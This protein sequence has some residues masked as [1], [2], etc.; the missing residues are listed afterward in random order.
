[1]P[2]LSTG[3]KVTVSNCNPCAVLESITR[4]AQVEPLL[5]IRALCYL[6]LGHSTSK[7]AENLGVTDR[8]FL[9]VVRGKRQSERLKSRIA[10]ALGVSRAAIFN[11]T[12]DSSVASQPLSAA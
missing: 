10:D 12:S 1:M 8:H 11:E 2:T 3:R 4:C 9:Y 6:L 5:K 7:L